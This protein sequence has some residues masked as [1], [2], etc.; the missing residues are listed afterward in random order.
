MLKLTAEPFKF[1]ASDSKGVDLSKWH[2]ATITQISNQT[3]L[4]LCTDIYLMH[5]LRDL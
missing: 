3:G 1:H 4:K 5:T 2:S